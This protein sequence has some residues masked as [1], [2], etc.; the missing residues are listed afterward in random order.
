MKRGDFAGDRVRGLV[1][2]LTSRYAKAPGP[3]R[4]AVP[5]VVGFV[6]VV[7]L[8]Y[9]VPLFWTN[10][11]ATAAGNVLLT[12][13]VGILFARARMLALCPLGFAAVACWF[14]GWCTVHGLGNFAVILVGS[15]VIVAVLGALV[16]LLAIRLRGMNLAVATIAVA[17]AAVIGLSVYPIPGLSEGIPVER[18]GFAPGDR[19]Y[20]VFS[21][22]VVIIT[23]VLL[24]AVLRS[25]LGTAWA[26]LSSE[27]AAAAAGT[28]VFLSKLTAFAGSAVLAA[29]SGVLLSGQQGFVDASVFSVGA[30]LQIV[31]VAIFV[32]AGYTE[33]AI[34]SGIVPVVLGEIFAKIG[35][36]VDVPIIFFGIGAIQALAQNPGGISAQNRLNRRKRRAARLARQR[37]AAG[38]GAPDPD[39]VAEPVDTPL[40]AGGSIR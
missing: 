1:T 36:P 4:L 24:S 15:I 40:G 30:N 13:S 29:I 28:N 11:G 33:G 22:A 23:L 8:A 9:S 34:L 20:L 14:A 10:L 2:P 21:A 5:P 12:A 18:P 19:A 27:R 16:G 26:M 38:L 35:L 17:S 39:P 32:G 25:R 31:V 3:V 7:I 6:V 37:A